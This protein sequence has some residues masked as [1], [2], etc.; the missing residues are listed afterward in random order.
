MAQRTC[1]GYE[2]DASRKFRQYDGQFEGRLPLTST[3]IARKCSLPVRV[4]GPN[5]NTF[6]EDAKSPTRKSRTSH[7]EPFSTTTVSFRQ[8]T[9]SLEAISTV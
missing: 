3:S 1:G 2:D 7:F 6:P 4:S 9:P 5:T 8:I